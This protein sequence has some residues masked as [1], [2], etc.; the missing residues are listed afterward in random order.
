MAKKTSKTETEE[1]VVSTAK[2]TEN[3]VYIGK[4][5]NGLPQY[6]IFKN[7]ELPPHIEA[8]AD[9]T[10]KGLIVP[11]SELQEARKNVH[12][13]GHILNFYLNKQNKK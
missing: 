1:A 5:I 3:T 4:S 11:V 9:D 13:K 10:I 12:K 8:M 6:T 2:K 7:G